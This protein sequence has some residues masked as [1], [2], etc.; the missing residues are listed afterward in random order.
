MQIGDRVKILTCPGHVW[1]GDV[2]TVI[3]VGSETLTVRKD[4]NDPDDFPIH[5]YADHFEPLMTGD[6]EGSR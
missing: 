4:G 6:T 2:G 1:R 3:A 5:D